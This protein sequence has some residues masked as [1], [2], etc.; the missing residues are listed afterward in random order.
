MDEPNSNLDAD[1]EVA[2]T[3]AIEGI[4]LRNGIAVIIA[5]R[6]SALVT[7]DFVA[8]IQNGRMTNFGKKDDVLPQVRPV[9]RARP[10]ALQELMA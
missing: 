2:L 6:P 8:V 5:H 9:N 7:V 3:R 1:G 4:K 10:G